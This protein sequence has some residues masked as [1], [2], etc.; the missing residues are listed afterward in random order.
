MPKPSKKQKEWSN[1]EPNGAFQLGRGMV[2]SIIIDI[3][4]SSY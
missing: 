1:D 3:R 2:E 4:V